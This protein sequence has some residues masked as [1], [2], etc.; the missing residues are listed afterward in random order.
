MRRVELP[1]DTRTTDAYACLEQ[2]WLRNEAFGAELQAAQPTP[3]IIRGLEE[4]AQRRRILYVHL[5]AGRERLR[6][7]VPA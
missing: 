1:S 5:L 2:A 4:F 6:H 3:E 7:A